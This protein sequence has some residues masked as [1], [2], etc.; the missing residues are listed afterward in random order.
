MAHTQMIGVVGAGV[1]GAGIAQVF[2]H[3]G[4][5]RVALCDLTDEQVQRGYETIRR[6]FLKMVSKEKMSETDM[7]GALARIHCT[8]DLKELAECSLV[9]EAV[10][11]QLPVKRT[12]LL[13]LEEVLS[14][15]AV[16]ASNTSTIPITEIAAAAEFPQRVIGM[17]F[18]NPAPVMKLVEVTQALQTDSTVVERVQDVAEQIGKTVVVSKDSTGFIVNRLLLPM[19]NEAIFLLS[20]GVAVKEDIDAA[21]KLGAAHP[22]GPLALADLI[23]LDVSLSI[24]ETLYADT[25]DPK[26]RP[27]PLL[28]RY[29]QAG[30]L[31]RKTGEG[32]FVYTS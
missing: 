18:F 17:H 13:K 15:E 25:G 32:F 16:I 3:A 22:M 31:G 5:F 28:R 12:I 19:V 14:P 1:M 29:V 20:E 7:E 21:M 6:G 24:M 4:M 2:A 23:G 27:A 8:T 30:K 26:Y 11:E 10:T 9:I